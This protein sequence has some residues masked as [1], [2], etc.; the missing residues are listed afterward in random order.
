[1]EP[2]DRTR[3]SGHKPQHRRFQLNGRKEF[4]TLR[5][6]EPWDRLPREGLGAPALETFPARLAV[7][8]QP[9]VGD[10]AVAGGCTGWSPEVPH[11]PDRSV[12]VGF[13][14][15]N[16]KK[17]AFLYRVLVLLNTETYLSFKY[18]VGL[19]WLVLWSF[20]GVVLFCFKYNPEKGNLD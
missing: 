4:F 7:T 18:C 12:I 17:I 20:L 11:N 8:V 2:S 13:A 1:M 3:G 9:A 6:A 10:P 19:G 14:D 5:V 15:Y 16:D